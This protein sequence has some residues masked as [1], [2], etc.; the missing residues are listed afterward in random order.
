MNKYIRTND[1]GENVLD[2]DKLDIAARVNFLEDAKLAATTIELDLDDPDFSNAEKAEAINSA[3]NWAAY[4][5]FGYLE[6]EDGEEVEIDK[7]T[8]QMWIETIISTLAERYNV[9]IE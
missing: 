6:T 5:E 7:P 2:Y 9:E 1:D 3:A 4:Q 8:R